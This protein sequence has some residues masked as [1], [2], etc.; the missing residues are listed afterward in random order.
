MEDRLGVITRAGRTLFDICFPWI[1]FGPRMLELAV[2]KPLS[3]QLILLSLKEIAESVFRVCRVQRPELIDATDQYLKFVLTDWKGE[4]TSYVCEEAMLISYS[5][6]SFESRTALVYGMIYALLLTPASDFNKCSRCVRVL[7][8]VLGRDLTHAPDVPPSLMG[9]AELQD[10]TV[11]HIVKLV[12]MLLHLNIGLDT[13][14]QWVLPF[15]VRQHAK[16]MRTEDEGDETEGPESLDDSPLAVLMMTLIRLVAPGG[17]TPDNVLLVESLLS[18]HLQV[19]PD[20]PDEVPPM[21]LFV[22]RCPILGL[23]LV[24]HLCRWIV[25]S[26]PQ[27]DKHVSL[28]KRLLNLP[29]I[30]AAI[31]GGGSEIRR[32]LC[33][34]CKLVNWTT[35]LPSLAEGSVS[36]VLLAKLSLPAGVQRWADFF[37]LYKAPVDSS[38]RVDSR[39]LPYLVNDVPGGIPENSTALRLLGEYIPKHLGLL[40]TTRLQ[41]SET[42]CPA[43]AAYVGATM[44][45]HILSG[46]IGAE[47]IDVKLT[48]VARL[49][50][51]KI[52]SYLPICDMPIEA[53]YVTTIYWLLSICGAGYRFP[54]EQICVNR[55]V[56]SEETRLKMPNSYIIG[57]QTAAWSVAVARL[58]FFS[59]LIDLYLADTRIRQLALL[60]KD[61]WKGVAL[62]VK[63]QTVCQRVDGQMLG[64]AFGAAVLLCPGMPKINAALRPQVHKWMHQLAALGGPLRIIATSLSDP[65]QVTRYLD[66]HWLIKFAFDHMDQDPLLT[67]SMTLAFLLGASHQLFSEAWQGCFIEGLPSDEK[68]IFSQLKTYTRDQV[69]LSENSFLGVFFKGSSQAPEGNEFRS[70]CAALYKGLRSLLEVNVD[71]YE[72][73]VETEVEEGEEPA[74][75]MA[76]QPLI[77]RTFAGA[78]SAVTAE[79]ELERFLKAGAKEPEEVQVP[80]P[81]P[82]PPP[83]VEVFP[84]PIPKERWSPIRPLRGIPSPPYVQAQ[85]VECLEA[86]KF[87]YFAV[88]QGTDFIAC[89]WKVTY[90]E[91]RNLIQILDQVGDADLDRLKESIDITLETMAMLP[92][93]EV[94]EMLRLKWLQPA[95]FW[96]NLLFAS[97]FHLAANFIVMRLC[98]MQPAPEFSA[99]LY[100]LVARLIRDNEA[101]AAGPILRLLCLSHSHNYLSIWDLLSTIRRHFV[102]HDMCLNDCCLVTAEEDLSVQLWQLLENDEVGRQGSNDL[103]G[104]VWL[105]IGSLL[106]HPSVTKECDMASECSGRLRLWFDSILALD[107]LDDELTLLVSPLFKALVRDLKN[108]STTATRSHANNHLLQNLDQ[109]VT[110]LFA[111]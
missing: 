4:I 10:H 14:L 65:T 105:M 39:A 1:F 6:S 3:H 71:W 89:P 76:E 95:V 68:L 101:A 108:S 31:G 49:S 57:I 30:C 83:P 13:L 106:I 60:M 19:R 63:I 54:L 97:E 62:N 72:A 21:L 110:A 12:V 8:C 40:L 86:L 33:E 87:R 99:I 32:A 58:A 91:V 53:R 59:P 78:G 37:L 56:L 67:T 109:V 85:I 29:R 98:L 64:M 107:S 70:L 81:P 38:L 44:S 23:T 5:D 9:V 7:E 75:V 27:V 55:D 42:L 82:P 102:T 90:E 36:S 43:L 26:F 22:D 103:G 100:S 77:L 17:T 35:P 104:F 18:L 25:A 20:A 94:E 11:T 15:V 61:V 96:V 41:R 28:L 16:L 51:P 84:D 73:I 88:T 34:A 45:A 74:P 2:V 92:L 111:S 50:C 52:L 69:H 93:F 46:G 48:F 24:T 79:K 80:P 47:S 66:A